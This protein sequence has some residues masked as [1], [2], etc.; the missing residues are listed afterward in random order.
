MIIVVFA[1]MFLLIRSTI[2]YAGSDKNH[3][4]GLLRMLIDYFHT[5][6]IIKYYDI[7]WPE[8]LESA[9]NI[10]SIIGEADEK[11]LSVDCFI[12]SSKYIIY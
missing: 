7:N 8:T 4:P 11:I 1:I 5:I 9:L 10:F 12:Q 3:E 6:L 2:I